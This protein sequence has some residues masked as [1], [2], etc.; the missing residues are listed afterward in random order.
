[1]NI[2]KPDSPVMDFISTVADIIILNLLFIICSL[3][4]VTFGAAYS[5]KY[6][7]VMKKVRGEDSGTIVPFFKAF[8]RNFKQSTIVWIIMLV[9]ISII[10]LDWQWIMYNGWS[11][12]PMIYRIGVIVFSVIALLITITAFP[13]IARYEMKTTEVFKAA[14]IFVIIKFIPLALILLLMIGSVVACLWYAQWFPLIYVFCSTTITYFLAIVF[15]KQFDKLEKAQADKLQALKDSVE[16]DPETDAAGNISL[17]A[18]KKDI[19]ELEKNLETPDEEQ[20][21]SGNKFTRFIKKE[22]KKLKG[23]TAKQKAQYLAQ[24]YL[25]GTIIIVLLIAAICWYGYDVYRDKMRVLAGGLINCYISEEGKEYATEGFLNW[26]GYAASRTAAVIDAEDLNFSSD[27]EYEGR[28][29]EVSFRASLLTGTYDYLIMR[30]DA[31]YNYSTP[32]YFQNMSDLVNMDNFTEDDFYY[33]VATEAEKERNSKGISLKDIFNTGEDEDE[34]EPV[35]LALKLTDDIERKLGLD[36]QYDYYLA[37]AYSTSA[38]GNSDYQR[39]IEYLFG[40]C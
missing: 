7:V 30:E 22:K 34:D 18:A 19:K 14:L 38:S 10:G 33:Y 20:D 39:F 1:M 3:P 5:A 32:D 27:S 17:A 40:K 4:I 36:E 16:Y 21:K 9:V 6:Y 25:P 28:Y 12:T 24:Y 35:P 15:I 23:L 13:T 29:L 2:L 8:K 31:V 26:G 11:N 37:F